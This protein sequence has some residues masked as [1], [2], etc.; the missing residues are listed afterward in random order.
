MMEMI[1]FM[2]M[3]K[4][5]LNDLLTVE[6][7]EEINRFFSDSLQMPLAFFANMKPLLISSMMIPYL[8]GEEMVSYEDYL[9]NK[10]QS[11]G[12]AIGGLETV[13][14]Q[15]GYIDRISVEDQARMLVEQVS[16][17]GK[18]RL[19]MKEMIEKY[20]AN[21]AQLLYNFVT[22]HSAEY[23]EF[24]EYLLAERNQ[25]WI[26]Q[27]ISLGAEQTTFVAVGAGHLGGER[28]VLNLLKQAGY[29][30]EPL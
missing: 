3:E 28:G 9:K 1:P 6:E 5:T 17:M 16:D 2:S 15:I 11:L 27:I 14:E 12:I 20:L 10:A 21:D 19:M 23:R 30:V 25:N 22:K 7:F 26:P 29:S 13:E 8:I 4:R 24:G 18:A